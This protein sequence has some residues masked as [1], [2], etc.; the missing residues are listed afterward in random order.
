MS[1]PTTLPRRP[2]PLALP[3]IVVSDTSPPL[4]SQKPT[5]R[6][7]LLAA[8]RSGT[9]RHTQRAESVLFCV[10]CPMRFGTPSAS[11]HYA[12]SLRF[13]HSVYSVGTVARFEKHLNPPHKTVNGMY[14]RF[15]WR[16]SA[17]TS[18]GGAARCCKEPGWA[19]APCYRAGCLGRAVAQ[20]VLRFAV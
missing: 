3:R 6:Q 14:Y 19:A 5:L 9:R 1:P 18:R 13:L 12:A 20:R 7:S 8:R 16:C 11:S 17:L 15:V 10:S 4:L 2:Y